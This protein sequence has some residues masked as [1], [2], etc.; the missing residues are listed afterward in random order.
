MEKENDSGS[1]TVKYTGT[2]NPL[3]INLPSSEY[4]GNKYIDI[5]VGAF[6]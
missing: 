2:A 1:F 6:F 4:K 5:E 3:I